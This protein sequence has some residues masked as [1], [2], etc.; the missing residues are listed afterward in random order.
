MATCGD[1]VS[2]CV[3]VGD[4]RP[5][6]ALFVEAKDNKTTLTSGFVADLKDKILERTAEFNTLL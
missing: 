4:K 2:K 3:V 5:F 1:I 6:P